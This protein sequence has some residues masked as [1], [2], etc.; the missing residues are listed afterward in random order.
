MINALI[1]WSL[2]NRFLVA[3]A[4]LLVIG[5][6]IKAIYMAPVDA[7]PDLSENQVIV[8]ADWM[9][10]SPREVEDQVTYPLSTLLQGLA[11]VKEVRAT[12][13]F[14]FSLLTVIFAE[15]VDPPVARQ[16]ITERLNLQGERL[17]QGVQARLGAGCDGTGVGFP[18]LPGGGPG[19]GSE[20][21]RLRL[22]GTA[23]AAGLSHPQSPECGA[24]SG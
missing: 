17:A 2:R 19:E 20:W 13:M 5:F 8:F 3:C 4:T 6:G 1:T 15:D 21:T 16:R 23:F 24:G 11:G 7:I 14:G 22:G 10:R 18:V 9:G 12:S